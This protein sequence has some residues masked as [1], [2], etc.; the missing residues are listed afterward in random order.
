VTWC[1]GHLLEQAPPEH[2]GEQYKRWSLESLPIVPET[3]QS[4]VKASARKQFAVI[5]RLLQQAREVVIAT[6]ADREGEMIAREVLDACAWRGPV[7]R[8]WLSALDEA[9]VR[10]ALSSLWPGAKTEP[11]YRAATSRA[12]ADW[13]VG[14]NLTRAYT[15]L[16]RAAGHDGVLSVGRVQTPTL[17][18][19]VDR[20]RAIAAFVPQPYWDVRVTLEHANGRFHGPVGASGAGRGQRG[21]LHQ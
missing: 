18:L 11:L 2:Y 20:D 7:Q 9:S 15:V 10:K 12:R 17:R 4:T 6:D 13:L 5:R 16:G 19:V 3:W 8:L 14:M 21:P 1:F